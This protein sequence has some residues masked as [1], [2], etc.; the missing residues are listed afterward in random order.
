MLKAF[1]LNQLLFATVG[2]CNTAE[3]VGSYIQ[4]GR[5]LFGL[6]IAIVSIGLTISSVIYIQRILKTDFLS[7]TFAAFELIV[8]VSALL[9]MVGVF[10]YHEKVERLFRK[11]LQIPGLFN[12]FENV[13]EIVFTNY[14]YHPHSFLDQIGTFE[15]FEKADGSAM[16]FTIACPLGI[17]LMNAISQI[18][19]SIIFFL[20]CYVNGDLNDATHL[21]RPFKYVYVEYLFQYLK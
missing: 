1:E 9:S 14:Y 5:R 6:S 20:Y 10:L 4:L 12:R 15:F 7:T 13:N 2:L 19:I 17:P 11:I 3:S 16:K 8:A 21:Y 18:G